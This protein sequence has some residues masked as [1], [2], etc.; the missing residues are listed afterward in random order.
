MV[1]NGQGMHIKH[2]HSNILNTS[3]H[4]KNLIPG[5]NK[6]LVSVSKFAKDNNVFFE[7]HPEFCLVKSQV[8]KEI[9][10]QGRLKDGLYGFDNIPVAHFPVTSLLPCNTNNPVCNSIS[11]ADSFFVWHEKLRHCGA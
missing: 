4:L 6:N 9:I 7:F 2:F 5:I 1:G 3:F 8:T 10:L 11:V